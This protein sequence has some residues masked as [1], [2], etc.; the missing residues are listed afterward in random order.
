MARPDRGRHSSM[1]HGHPKHVRPESH[2]FGIAVGHGGV[3]PGAAVPPGAVGS[4]KRDLEASGR[5]LEGQA[6]EKAQFDELGLER[7]ANGELLEGRVQVP[8]CP[9]DTRWRSARRDPRVRAAGRRR[10]SRAPCGGRFRPGCGAS[11]RRRQQKNVGD[12]PSRVAGAGSPS[13][14][15]ATSRKYASWTSAV[16]SSV[17]PGFSWASFCAATL[18]RSSYTSGNSWLAASGSPR[19]IASSAPVISCIASRLRFGPRALAAFPA[20]RFAEA[21][22]RL[23]VALEPVNTAAARQDVPPFLL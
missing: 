17:W 21:G 16:G 12:W 20:V 4:G 11:P 10:A 8:E 9:A 23:R 5:L 13:F 19:S 15:P 2:F 6:A 14:P 7:V 1:R 22:S 3:Q 18:R